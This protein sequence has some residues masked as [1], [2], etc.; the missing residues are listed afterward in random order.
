MRTLVTGAAG[1]IGCHLAKAL[2]AKGDFVRC[3]IMPHEDGG[4]LEKLGVEIVRGDLTD[5]HSIAGVADTIDIVFHLA[6][7]T[8]DW[9]SRRQFEAVMV[10]GTRNLLEG[11]AGNVSRFV[12]CSSIA[13]LGLGRELAGLNEDAHRLKTFIPYCDTKIAAE[14]LVA[15]FC[16]Q[17]GLAHTIVRPANVIGPGSV[18]VRDILDAFM[19]GPLPLIAKGRAPGAFVYIDNLVDGITLAGESDNAVGRVYHFRDDFPITWGEYLGTLGRWV[20]KHPSMGLPYRAAWLLGGLCEA[21]CTP[22]GVRPP[23]SRLAAGVM[24]V[25]NEVDAGRAKQELGWKPK[26]R[27][28]E[29]MA[30]I[31][32][33][34]ETAYRPRD[35]VKSFYNKCVVITGGSSGIGLETAA[36]LAEKGAHLLLVARNKEKLEQAKQRISS[37]RLG[38]HQ[39]IHTLDLDITRPGEVDSRLPVAAGALG[40]VDILI[41]SAGILDTNCFEKTSHESFDAV[42]QTNVYGTR[43]VIAS[44]LP[45]MRASGRGCIVNIGSGAGLMGIFGY[46]SYCASK[47]AILGLSESLRIELKSYNIFVSVVCPPRVITPMDEQEAL[48]LP[49]ETRAM[50]RLGGKLAPEFVAKS[51][52]KGIIKKRFLIIPG[53]L[54]KLQY[55]IQRCLGGPITRAAADFI[56]KLARR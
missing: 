23:M 39:K 45:K 44:L 35:D 30:R 9:G 14:D 5:P 25:D 19:K 24:G 48:S 27:Q 2:V 11:A 40:T 52:V 49:P 32:S 41:N 28:D 37:R 31:K 8:A 22:L 17:N 55:L 29:A 6:A 56:V 42:I 18:W 47:Y 26:V 50:K 13:A 15:S 43:N 12:Y 33:W 7:R 3:L 51:V 16:R 1:F 38:N 36:L 54:M 46:T 53:G 21:L 20:G 4:E 34:V 10:A